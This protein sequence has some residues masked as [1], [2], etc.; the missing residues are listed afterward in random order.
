MV[1]PKEKRFEFVSRALPDD[2]FGVVSF[3]G[4]EGFSMCYEF[5]IDL[6]S[7]NAEI[8]LK[9]VLRSPAT[10][11]ILREEEN[12]IPFHGILAQFEQL[13][14]VDEHVFY[15]A[16]LVPKLWWLSLT[17]HNQVILNKTV[18][19]IISDVLKDGG[20]STLD[21]E[22]KLEQEYP[23][24][25][26]ICQYRESHLDFVSR[27]MEREGMYYYFKQTPNGEK[28]IIADTR[29][30]HT[31]MPEGKTMYYSPPSGLDEFHREEVIKAFVCRQKLL[32]RS[33]RLKDYNY[34]TP[35]LEISGTAEV[36]AD[37]RGDVYMYGEHFRTPREGNDLAK[38]RAEELLCQEQRFHGES[39]IP[40]LRP[41]Y[42][43]DLEDHYRDN[44]NQQYLT[45]ELAHE[46]SQ[47]AYLLAGIR[48]GL[49]AVEQEAYYRNDF[50]AIPGDVQFRPERKTEKPRFYGT[51][52]AKVDAAGTGRYAELD[53][54][55][56]YKIVLPL[57]VSGRKDGK[58]SAFFRM[59]QPYAGSDHGMHF[60]LHKG[61]EVLLTFIDGDPDRPIISSSVSNPETPN[62]VNS[63]NA[64]G[65]GIRTASGNQI[66]MQDNEGHER[67]IIGSG[68]GKSQI[69]CGS[70][71]D[72]KIISQSDYELF[73]SQNHTTV[74]GIASTLMSS[75]SWS[76]LSGSLLP[77][78]TFNYLKY[79]AKEYGEMDE[80]GHRIGAIEEGKHFKDTSTEFQVS[81]AMVPQVLN[82]IFDNWATYSLLKHLEAQQVKKGGKSGKVQQG[83]NE[84]WKK[85]NWRGRLRYIRE[86]TSYLSMLA[87]AYG[88][89]TTGTYG[90]A[91]FSHMPPI[92]TEWMNK[93]WIKGLADPRCASVIK[94]NKALPDVL[95][96]SSVGFVDVIGAKG[97]H[98]FSNEIINI[99]ANKE[100]SL[101]ALDSL[102]LTADKG[103][104]AINRKDVPYHMDL[105]YGTSLIRI[106]DGLM[107]HRTAGDMEFTVFKDDN[108]TSMGSIAVSGSTQKEGAKISLDSKKC[109]VMLDGDK[110]VLELRVTEDGKKPMAVITMDLSSKRIQVMAEN[111]VEIDTAEVKIGQGT[112]QCK[113]VQMGGGSTR[114][115]FRG[116]E[117][118]FNGKKIKIG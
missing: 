63:G 43:F 12:N 116:S 73:C 91:L 67:I 118:N 23:P 100:A 55:G 46:G 85:N 75:F 14:E 57:D 2:T 13:H 74:S 109:A 113:S 9:S 7:R 51:M 104:I 114:I 81:M 49:A 39:T 69:I 96:A 45:V 89:G 102:C 47:A 16:I 1:N 87:K 97:V 20:L 58:A 60:P 24:W 95:V 25:E 32:P 11:T 62:I 105:E 72:S 64:T 26:Y 82:V 78:F 99:E 59:A 34:R 115:N 17:H 110:D 77:H 10:F 42:L 38:I 76:A 61:T 92:Q 106:S 90:V 30:A 15:R 66:S 65:A 3:S 94:L 111:A 18:P 93:D 83:Y 31:D 52:N 21:F 112:Q 36:S 84:E 54:H 41:G 70:G 86:H 68:D 117:F 80:L 98:L 28:A 88:I 40:Y 48:K 79:L 56:R 50:V 8:D 4:S 101:K 37:G 71:S 108:K 44:F 27:W 35:S 6:V 5:R 33:V 53:K 103:I 22:L 19:D 29:L 107:Q